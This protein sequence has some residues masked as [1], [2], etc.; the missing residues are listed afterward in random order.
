MLSS[1]NF[2]K[3]KRWFKSKLNVSFDKNWCFVG[4]FRIIQNL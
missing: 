3:F 2:L 1:L 4:Y